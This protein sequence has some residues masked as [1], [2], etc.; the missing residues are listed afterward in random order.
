MY[1]FSSGKYINKGKYA[2]VKYLTNIMSAVG[3]YA[4]RGNIFMIIDPAAIVYESHFYMY[5]IQYA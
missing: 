3:I 2:C 4:N 1:A 5:V